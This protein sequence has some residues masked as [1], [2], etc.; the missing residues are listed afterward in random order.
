MPKCEHCLNDYNVPPGFEKEADIQFMGVWLCDRHHE[1]EIER[2]S[3]RTD[4][5]IAVEID[6]ITGI[7]RAKEKQEIRSVLP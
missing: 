6:R 5:M 7:L 1:E 3:R 4:L 2:R